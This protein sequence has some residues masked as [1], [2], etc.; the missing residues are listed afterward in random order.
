MPTGLVW[1]ERY[2]WHDTRHAGGPSAGRGWIEPARPLREPG[3]EAADPQ[4]ARRQRPARAA[5]PHRA[6][7]CDRR[8]GLPLPHARATSTRSRR[9]SDDNGGDAGGLTPFGPGSFEIAL[10]LGRRHDRRGRRRARR[11][12]RQ[13]LR[14]RAPARPP[15]AS[16]IAAMGFCLFGNVAIAAHHARAGARGRARRGR[17]LGRP[18]RQRHAGRVLR[19]PDRAHDLAAPGQ[20]LPAGL[21]ADRRARRGRRRG[22]QHQ[23]PAAARIGRRRLPGGVRPGRRAGA[24]RFRPEPVVHRQRVRR[25]RHGPARAPDAVLGQLPGA[26]APR[27]GRRRASA[28]TAA[29]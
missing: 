20:L 9:C 15:R 21:R 23:R 13:R 29:S 1:H 22:L 17:R 27:H 26:H 18:P 4:P 28:A 2:M 11:H 12:G 5:R 7:R 24:A 14:A 8:R 16:P 6:A 10:L 19:R 25:E 3:H